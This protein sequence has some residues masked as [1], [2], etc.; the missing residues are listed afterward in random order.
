MG[1]G[2]RPA[3]DSEILCK[4][5]DHP[6]IHRAPARDHPIACGTF[7]LHAEIGAAMGHEHVEFFKAA[8]IQQQFDPLARGQLALGMLRINAALPH[9]PAGRSARWL[10]SCCKMSFMRSPI[11][12]KSG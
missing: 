11:V 9:P 10:S 1:F 2:H 8:L 5:I 4:D 3:H 12:T 6:A 7:G